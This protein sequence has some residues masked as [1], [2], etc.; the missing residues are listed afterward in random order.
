MSD[1]FLIARQSVVP[2]T[3]RMQQMAQSDQFLAPSTRQARSIFS[4][5]P[6]F[7]QVW[8]S[9]KIFY[10]ALL[11]FTSFEISCFRKVPLP[12]PHF[13]VP[14]VCLTKTWDIRSL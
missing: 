12:V 9:W 8:Q 4:G 6:F 7:G 3:L 5:V 13:M 14:S 2:R 10:V 11:N 1:I